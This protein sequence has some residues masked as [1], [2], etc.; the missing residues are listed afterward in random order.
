MAEPYRFGGP[1]PESVR[2]MKLRRALRRSIPRVQ[3]AVLSYAH[4][5]D[6]ITKTSDGAAVSE[7]VAEIRSL[8]S[9]L[10]ALR[11]VSLHAAVQ[12]NRRERAEEEPATRGILRRWDAEGMP[13]RRASPDPDDEPRRGASPDEV[14]DSLK[15]ERSRV[16]CLSEELSSPP[17]SKHLPIRPEHCVPEP[18]QKIDLGA[19]KL[20]RWLFPGSDGKR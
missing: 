18:I 13:P 12:K 7:L 16:L 8:R 19:R 3:Q 5:G 4:A 14:F 20:F 2:H 15:S 10:A 17:C 6:S 9:G 11:P 1:I